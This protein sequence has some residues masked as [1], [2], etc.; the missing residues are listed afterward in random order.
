MSPEHEM[1]IIMN[2]HAI[3]KKLLT[4]G[5]SENQAEGITEA[6][7]EVKPD[8]ELY[9]RKELFEVSETKIHEN[10][11]DIGIMKLDIIEVK[12]KLGTIE[13]RLDAVENRLDAVE[14]R[15][16]AVESRLS[17]IEKTL[18]AVE[19]ELLKLNANI[20][21][22]LAALET[23]IVK[24]VLPLFFGTMVSIMVPILLKFYG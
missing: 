9:V 3:F 18:G 19:Y 22:K 2:T 1:E 6:I 21:P 16:V 7:S 8:P 13:N 5:F 4:Y 11:N 23:R 15:L 12:M 20:D 24:W 10:N 14:N 17:A